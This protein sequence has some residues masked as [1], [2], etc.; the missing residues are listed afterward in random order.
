MVAIAPNQGQPITNAMGIMTQVFRTW[1]QQVTKAVPLT[2]T[3]NPE[4]VVEASQGQ[5][6]MDDAGVEGA[7]LYVKRDA[8]IAGDRTKGWILT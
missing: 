1:T 6:Y 2:G 4:D 3:G 7:I 8:D 5:L